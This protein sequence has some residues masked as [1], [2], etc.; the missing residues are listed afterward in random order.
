H[1]QDAL[2]A[3]DGAVE[4]IEKLRLSGTNQQLRISYFASVQDYYDFYISLLMQ[5]HKADRNAGFAAKALHIYERGRARGLIDLL[6]EA[7][8][9]LHAGV[10][11]SLLEEE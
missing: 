8:I 5:L 9:D 1:F 6:T 10:D 2:A 3:I 4:I 11:E 7:Q